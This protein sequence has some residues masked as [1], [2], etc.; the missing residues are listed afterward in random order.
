MTDRIAEQEIIKKDEK[1]SKKA[2][3]E[4]ASKVVASPEHPQYSADKAVAA[5]LVHGRS[6]IIAAIDGVGKGGQASSR[7]AEI[8]QG[9][10]IGLKNLLS[11]TPTLSEA[12][13]LLKNAIFASSLEIKELQKTSD[14]DQIDTT[15]SAGVICESPNGE[16]RFL[17]TANAG[18]SSTHRYR[19]SSGKVDKLTSDHSLVESLV[20]AGIISP[21]EVFTHPKRSMVY[22]T[23]SSLRSPKHI[24]FGV[25]EIQ[26]GDLFFAVS[27]GVSDN[28]RAEGLTPAVQEEFQKSFNKEQ[29]KVDLKK[30]AEAIARRARNIMVERRAIQAKPDDICVAVLRVPRIG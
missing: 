21:E 25:H 1:I 15:V 9:K 11:K 6:G 18:D 19:P 30:F 27:D 26:E 2:S 7:A 3:V 23:V 29:K 8:V 17:L 16:R 5:E 28:I 12:T 22:R 13:I 14:D 4:V 24:D 10:L 20:A